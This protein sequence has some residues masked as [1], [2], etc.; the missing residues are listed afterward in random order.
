M[1]ALAAVTVAGLLAACGSSG[2]SSS[3]ATTTNSATTAS[4]GTS[5]PAAAT[6]SPFK[7][8]VTGDFTSSG[9]AY[10]TP[11]VVPAAKG[12]LRNNP[13][14][15]IVTCDTK[16]TAS[17]ADACEEQAVQDK[18]AAVIVGFSDIDGNQSILTKAGIPDARGHGLR[19]LPPRRPSRSPNGLAQYYGI[20]IGMAEGGCQSYGTLYLDGTDAL[21]NAI[22]AGAA[23]KGLKEAARAAVPANSPDLAPAVAKLTDAGVDCIALSVVPTQIVQAV[24]AINQSG[25]KVK[26]AAVSAIFVSQILSALGPALNGAISINQVRDEQR[27]IGARH[28]P[29]EERHGGDRPQ[30]AGY[31]AS[32]HRMGGRQAAT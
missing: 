19:R 18:V 30:S 1:A 32:R 2:K 27:H 16:S 23:T 15:T 3:S 8:M 6:S 28:N 25:K 31:R 7:V 13:N 14:I 24:T 5:A 26:V 10:T 21:A 9:L 11:E 4:S 29:G 17:A 22:K 20:G 12:A